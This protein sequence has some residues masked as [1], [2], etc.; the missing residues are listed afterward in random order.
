MDNTKNKE[1]QSKEIMKSD[2]WRYR[3]NEIYH[4]ITDNTDIIKSYINVLIL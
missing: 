4:Q 3:N 1:I 2:Y